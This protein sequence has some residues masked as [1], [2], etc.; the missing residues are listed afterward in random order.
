MLFSIKQE[1]GDQFSGNSNKEFSLN[2]FRTIPF[3]STNA[4]ANKVVNC[5]S[6]NSSSNGGSNGNASLLLNNEA[7]ASGGCLDADADDDDNFDG[8]GAGD[9]DGRDVD[10]QQRQHLAASI[11]YEDISF[12]TSNFKPD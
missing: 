10:D 3:T 2:D 6:S 11:I 8:N 4:I 5:N 12:D 9:D 7:V 1:F